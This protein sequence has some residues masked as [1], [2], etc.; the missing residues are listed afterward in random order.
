MAKK[1]D[2]ALFKVALDL[3]AQKGW[4]RT[5]LSDIAEAAGMPL[6]ELYR[7]FRSKRALL[8]AFSRRIDEEVL[9]NVD[10][11]LASEPARDRLFSVLMQ[12]FD[13][14]GPYKAGLC[15]VVR[16]ESCDPSALLCGAPHLT[17]SMAWMLEAAGIGSA[18]F[19]GALRVKGLAAIYLIALGVWFRDKSEDM[20]RTMATLDRSLRRVDALL[21]TL[22]RRGPAPAP[23]A[24]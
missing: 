5:T 8:V 11:D 19:G 21:A 17:R 4:G 24:P 16:D 15:A 22:K 3:A 7:Q 20:S 13:A 18:G 9:A 6:A 23:A 2:A 12:R 14:L 10:P 1:K